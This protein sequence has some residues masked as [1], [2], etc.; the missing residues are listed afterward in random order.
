ML[1]VKLIFDSDKDLI[2]YFHFFIKFIVS[3]LYAP[4]NER[5]KSNWFVYKYVNSGVCWS[6]AKCVS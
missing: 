1:V 3:I 2:T 4:V 5:N 6:E